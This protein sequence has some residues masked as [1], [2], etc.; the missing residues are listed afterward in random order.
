M[1]VAVAVAGTQFGSQTLTSVKINVLQ[2]VGTFTGTVSY[3]PATNAIVRSDGSNW[4]ADGFLEG[5]RIRITGGPNAGDYKIA[6]IDGPDGSYGTVM[7][8]TLERAIVA[9][10]PGTVTVVQT[11]A[12]LTFTPGNFYVPQA[13]TLKAD[14]NFTIPFFRTNV[15]PFPVLPHLLSRI[16]GPL[17]VEGGI[18][19][20]DRSLQHG[21]HAAE[22]AQRRP[23][24]HR[25]A[26]A[27]VLPG[28][29][30]ERVR[31][32]EP[33]GQGRRGHARRRSP[34]S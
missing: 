15:K 25:E 14:G 3:D 18:T 23:A 26:A 4:I 5:Q 31:R 22:R 27:R 24:Q 12:Q 34:A 2:R 8:L 11:A 29:H 33:G 30:A 32:L 20:A 16:R 7:H 6:L 10:A 21:D 28:R 13:V 19:G 17:E 9:G 1:T